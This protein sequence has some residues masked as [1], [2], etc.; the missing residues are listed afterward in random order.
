MQQNH[1]SLCSL[2]YKGQKFKEDDIY[3][4]SHEL[5][6]NLKPS[7]SDFMI[8][9]LDDMSDKDIREFA[10]TLSHIERRIRDFFNLPNI[11]KKVP[12]TLKNDTCVDLQSLQI[13]IKPDCVRGWS[14]GDTTF[15]IS[16]TFLKKTMKIQDHRLWQSF[17]DYTRS[18]TM[19]M[20]KI[21]EVNNIYFA[22]MKL[23]YQSNTP[24]IDKRYDAAY[25]VLNNVYL[26]RLTNR[27]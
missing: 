9:E 11:A 4:L 22:L 13:A 26:N 16:K 6:D 17:Y 5:I 24:H 12:T 25:I 21:N 20:L 18:I 19:V 8:K 15:R 14:Y 7:N 23:F 3:L 10:N 1:T 2:L 27:T